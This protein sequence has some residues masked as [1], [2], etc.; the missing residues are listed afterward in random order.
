MINKLYQFTLYTEGTG[1]GKKCGTPYEISSILTTTQP[2]VITLVTFVS[3]TC[4]LE[5]SRGKA[6]YPSPLGSTWN[7]MVALHGTWN[8]MVGLLPHGGNTSMIDT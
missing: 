1:E 6:H 5:W 4:N 7:H 8:H 3:A 2:C